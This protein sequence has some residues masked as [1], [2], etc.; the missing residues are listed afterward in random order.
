MGS[1]LMGWVRRVRV[2]GEGHRT[3]ADL[4]GVI[5]NPLLTV[6]DFPLVWI[7]GLWAALLSPAGRL[8]RD[9]HSTHT[10]VPS[11]RSSS[12][13]PSQFLPCMPQCA[14]SWNACEI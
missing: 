10:N 1:T 4:W 5:R 14:P 2:C 13:V 12:A 7:E 3:E 9:S 11:I 8:L 6:G